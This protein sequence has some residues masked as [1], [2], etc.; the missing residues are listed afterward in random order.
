MVAS[1][2]VKE[3]QTKLD[4]LNKTL[5]VNLSDI[6]KIYFQML[7]KIFTFFTK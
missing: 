3:A 4:E 6:L 5:D 1:D 7:S 2:Y